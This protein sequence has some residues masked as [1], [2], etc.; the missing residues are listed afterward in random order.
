MK[1]LNYD[2]Q[3]MFILRLRDL[4]DLFIFQYGKR[5]VKFRGFRLVYIVIVFGGNF[6]FFF[7]MVSINF[8][9]I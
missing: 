3:K 8:I 7:I 1:K 6:G 4:V 9:S 5:L 2:E